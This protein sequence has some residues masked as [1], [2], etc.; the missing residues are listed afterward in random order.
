MTVTVNW[1]TMLVTGMTVNAADVGLGAVA[2]AGTVE[3][4]LPLLS[5]LWE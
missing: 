5:S 4:A 3:V 1:P 2:A